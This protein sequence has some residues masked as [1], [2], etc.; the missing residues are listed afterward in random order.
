M[1]SGI[2]E[3]SSPYARLREEYRSAFNEWAF[4]VNHLHAVIANEPQFV[5]EAQEK[6]AMAELAYRNTRNRLIEG[7]AV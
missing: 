3:E 7:L 2:S 5:R 6:V 1:Q 4:Q